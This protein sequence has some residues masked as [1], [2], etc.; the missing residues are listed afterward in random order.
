[1][2]TEKSRQFFQPPILG[3]ILL[4]L[5]I[6]AAAQKADLSTPRSTVR[7]FYE[8]TNSPKPKREAAKLIS[9][10][11]VMSRKE[12]ISLV[13]QL[14]HYL[15]SVGVT[16][17]YDSLPDNPDYYDSARQ[18]YEFVL[19]QDIFLKKYSSIWQ[20]SRETVEKIPELVK[21]PESDTSATAAV[22]KEQ[23]IEER[24]R[25]R[26]EQ[27]ERIAHVPVD[28]SSPYATLKFYLDNREKNP[29][30]ASRIISSSD[31]P[32]LDDRLDILEK[33]N[34]FLDGKGVIIDLDNV[35]DDP[36]YRDTTKANSPHIYEITYRF[37]DIYLEKQGSNWYLSKTSAERIPELYKQAFPLGIDWLIKYLPVDEG[38]RILGLQ[39]WQY[40][41]ILLLIILAYLTFRFLNW[42][43]A[44]LLIRL[45]RK[46]GKHRL[47]DN[48]VGPIVRPIALLLAF[49]LAEVLMPLLQL[50]VKVTA[51]FSVAIEIL[52]PVFATVVVYRSMDLVSLYL[53]YLSQ[54]AR[55]SYSDQ[56]IP[57]VRKILK[58][59][60]VMIGAVYVLKNLN[61]DVKLLLGGL[62]VG[63]LALA[64]AAQD[65]IKN[66]FG[67]LVILIDKPFQSGHWITTTDGIDGTVEEVGMRST[68][69]RTFANSVISVPNGKLS[70]Q[71]I[72]NYGLRVYRRFKT[73]IAVTY[74][75]PPDVL[76]L[77]IE[78]LRKLVEEHPHTRKDYHHVYLNEMGD[79]S[80]NILF[81]IFFATPKYAEELQYRHEMIMSIIRLA[82]TL[83]VRF[84][85]PTQTLHMETFPGQ[86]PLTPPHE[87]G[88]KLRQKFD[89]FFAEKGGKGDATK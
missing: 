31:I 42:I 82:D 22:E 38:K 79:H 51:M 43:M 72:N 15:D 60:V 14:R 20:F 53:E 71:A 47:A 54:K 86:E 16:F 7:S 24:N 6:L 27:L 17:V 68:R 25:A 5:P 3:T 46:L 33:L 81:Y 85:F 12:R 63:G 35:P 66:F 19:Y 88:A 73:Q 75:T 34:R 18:A 76:E 36:D 59:F 65:T 78:G 57:L 83:G 32:H 4:L 80:L 77:F 2:T 49:I 61:I 89:R 26:S 69:I 62:S 48:Y 30:L 23:S 13:N 56:L 11:H 74:D 29:L 1:M 8:L 37:A 40:L 58:G 9:M 21:Q 64:L 55:T 44:Y 70:D 41:G 87:S 84:A 39:P 50:P 28:L 52:I 45:L 10:M 67:S